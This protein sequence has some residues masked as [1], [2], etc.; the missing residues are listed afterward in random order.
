MNLA[1]IQPFIAAQ[2]AADAPL[3]AFG[4][5]LQFDPAADPKTTADAIAARVLSAGVA[6]EVDVPGVA[7]VSDPLGASTLECS[8]DLFVSE[9]LATAHSPSGLALVDAVIAAVRHRT[10]NLRLD[11]YEHA[12]T[13]QGTLLHIL[14][15]SQAIRSP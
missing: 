11:G 4:A 12:R 10:A 5:V 15:F 8:F 9:S 14:S 1:G 7:R 13:A 2:I 3:A 6:I